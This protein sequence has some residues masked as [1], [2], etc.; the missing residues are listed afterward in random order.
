MDFDLTQKKILIIGGGYGGIGVLNQ[1]Q[2]QS[3]QP[4]KDV[5]YKEFHS[6]FFGL[7]ELLLHNYKN[8]SISCMNFA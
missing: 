1:I 5:K 8:P 2:K 7:C 4:L 3:W 6:S